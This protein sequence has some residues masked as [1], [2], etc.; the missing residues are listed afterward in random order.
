MEKVEKV[1]STNL[2]KIAEEKRKKKE[3]EKWNLKK[4]FKAILNKI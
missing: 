3:M 4:K 1:T 2:T